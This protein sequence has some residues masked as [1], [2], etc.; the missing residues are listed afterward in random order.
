MTKRLRKISMLLLAGTVYASM[1]G[2]CA[3]EQQKEPDQSVEK[4]DQP[5]TGTDGDEKESDADGSNSVA[6]TYKPSDITFP[7]QENYEDPG[8]GLKFVLPERLLQAMEK[9]EIAMLT[10]A[11]AE[12]QVSLDYGIYTFSAMTAEQRDAEV[13]TGDGNAFYEWAGKLERIGAI[14][15]YRKDQLDQLDQLTKCGSHKKI[16][17]SSD[18]AYTYYLSTNPDADKTLVKAVTQIK[19]E[20]IDMLPLDVAENDGDTKKQTGSLG[21]FSM[22]DIEGNTYTQEMFGDYD[23]TMINVFATWCTPCVNEIPDLQKLYEEMSDK[24]VNVVG[25]VL[26]TADEEGNVLNEG[27]EKARLLAERTKASYPFLIPD[28]DGLDGRLYGIEAVPETFFVDKN[29]NITGKTYSGSNSLEGWREV[30]E[31]ELENLKGAGA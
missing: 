17:K 10:E 13:S 3:S 11:L 26:D 19:A 4:Q 23:L 30:V 9:K 15:G 24:G 22:K 2:G 8:L 7:C 21:N 1:L 25:I 18:G 6:D 28:A 27:L 16:G 14:G 31:S 20:I 12:D 5:V 29:G